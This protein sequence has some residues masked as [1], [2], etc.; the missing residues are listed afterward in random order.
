MLDDHQFV[1][2]DAAGHADATEVVAFEVDQ[3]HVLGALLGM[4]DQLAHARGFVVG[5]QTRPRA[6]DGTR[7]DQAVAYADQALGR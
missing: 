4:T 5:S 6:G 2:L 7:L 3:H 1:D